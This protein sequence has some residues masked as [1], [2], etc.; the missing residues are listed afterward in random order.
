MGWE[1]AIRI[2]KVAVEMLADVVQAPRIATLGAVYDT[3]AAT[4]AR[5]R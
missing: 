4:W 3:T 5:E 2:P 1:T